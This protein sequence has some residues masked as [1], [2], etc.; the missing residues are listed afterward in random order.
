MPKCAAC[1]AIVE[2]KRGAAGHDA[3]E[4]TSYERG[5]KPFG[6]ARIGYVYYA[7]Q[8]CGTKWRYED[9]KNDSFVGWSVDA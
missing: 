5:P 9:D 1:E 6:Q 7:C 3:L 4:K 2:H 8:T